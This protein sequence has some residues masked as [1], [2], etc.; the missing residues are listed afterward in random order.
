MTERWGVVS[1][2]STNARIRSTP[3]VSSNDNVVG[4]GRN[5]DRVQIVGEETINGTSW[6]N[7]RYAEGSK[8]G[9]ISGTLVTLE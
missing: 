2:R 8:Q 7:I 3:G 4:W 6:Y 1:V 5:G 9:W